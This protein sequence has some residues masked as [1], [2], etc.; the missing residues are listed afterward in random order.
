MNRNR[1]LFVVILMLAPASAHAWST[2]PMTLDL[3]EAG[4]QA[5]P[6]QNGRPMISFDPQE[7]PIIDLSGTWKKKR[8]K[9]N[10][11]VTM[12]PR[13]DAFFAAVETES[14]GALEPTFNDAGWVNHELPGVENK[15]PD[16][17][18]DPSGAEVY[19][20]GVYYRR[21][22]NVPADWEGTGR[23]PRDARGGLRRRRL[24][25]RP[26]GGLPRRRLCAVRLRRFDPPELRR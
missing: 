20:R 10:H 26:L 23:P 8:L 19:S 1:L 5:I 12:G 9:F 14:D 24:D 18:D 21:H 11:D 4:G 17:P 13:D 22:V 6:M 3:A 15:M 7:R 25:Q 16:T 2:L